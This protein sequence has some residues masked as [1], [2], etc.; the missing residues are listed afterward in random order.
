MGEKIENG[1][2]HVGEI[3]GKTLDGKDIYKFT[4]LGMAENVKIIAP[5]YKDGDFVYEDGR[6]MIVKSYPS[7][8]HAL[9]Y[10]YLDGKAIYDRTYG[11]NF[12]EPTFR[13][14][15]EEEKQILIDAMKK[16]SKRWN[17]EKKCVEDIPP[18]RKFKKG[19]KVRTKEGISSR[20]V[21]S[22]EPAFNTMMDDFIDTT[23]TVNRYSD[24]GYVICEESDWRF[25]EEWLEPYT[26]E[27]NEGDLA[28]FWNN[29]SRHYA[30]VRMYGGLFMRDYCDTGGVRWDNAIKFQSKEQFERL[31]KGKL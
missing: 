18:V 29:G 30:S 11:V 23:M 7:N 10:P 17:A 2:I 28:I 20:T 15:T 1:T 22:N 9:V 13:Y 31:I 3:I 24:Y 14:A 16:D 26:D 8:C 5:Q 4:E 12:S 6:I 19:D 27:L 25:H 21:K